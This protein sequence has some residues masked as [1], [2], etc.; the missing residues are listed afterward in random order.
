MKRCTP[1]RRASSASTKTPCTSVWMNSPGVSIERSTCDSAGE[2]EHERA[3]GHGAQ[4]RPRGRAD[5]PVHERQTV[6]RDAV[7]VLAAAG[8]GERVEHDH[9]RRRMLREQP[10]H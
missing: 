9:V 2:V 4:P 1:T 7:E 8:V 6:G 5:V 3:P 10:M